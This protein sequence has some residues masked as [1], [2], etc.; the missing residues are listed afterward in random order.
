[1]FYGFICINLNEYSIG[2]EPITYYLEGNCSTNW[3]KS[4][5][6]FNILKYIFGY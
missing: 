4:K 5:N 1:M 2:F 3:A 6:S